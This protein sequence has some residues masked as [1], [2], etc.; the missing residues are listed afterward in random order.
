VPIG[1][2]VLGSK[3]CMYRHII[4]LLGIVLLAAMLNSVSVYEQYLKYQYNFTQLYFIHSEK[5]AQLFAN[6]D[7][8]MKLINARREINKC[9]IQIICTPFVVVGTIF[10][11]VERGVT[12]IDRI[13]LAFEYLLPCLLTLTLIVIL[14]DIRMR[15]KR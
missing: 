6:H 7:R 12:T 3:Q 9:L 2:K 11:V 4:C 14:N 1:I 10:G 15:V 8:I 13:I 5:Y